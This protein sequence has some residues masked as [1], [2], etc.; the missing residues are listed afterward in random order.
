MKQ[1]LSGKAFF[2][3]TRERGGKTK[4]DAEMYGVMGQQLRMNPSLCV[5][6]GD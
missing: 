6:F 5:G 4:R 3:R 2:V 1:V